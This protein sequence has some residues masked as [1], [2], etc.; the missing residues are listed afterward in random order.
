[1]NKCF[2]TIIFNKIL[3]Y[4]GNYINYFETKYLIIDRDSYKYNDKYKK[5]CLPY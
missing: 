3:K 2:K 4:K 5:E 1:M